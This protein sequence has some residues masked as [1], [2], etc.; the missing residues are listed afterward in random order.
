MTVQL[1]DKPLKGNF[2]ITCPLPGND[3]TLSP[4]TT[5]DIK[6]SEH[7]YWISHSI[8]KNCSGFYDKIDV[9]KGNG[10][11]EYSANGVGLYVRFTG[12]N[13]P[14]TQMRIVSG[15]DSALKQGDSGSADDLEYNST[16]VMNASTSLFYEAIPFEFLRTYE[17][18]P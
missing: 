18:K 14:Q 15:E 6:L 8:S 2:R 16:K 5:N 12:K 17:E 11:F 1:S 3:M 9:W 4:I 7:E 10:L 13:G